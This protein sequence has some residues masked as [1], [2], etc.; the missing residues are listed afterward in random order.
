MIDTVID[1]VEEES[2][3]LSLH[4]TLCSLRYNQLIHKFTE[5]DVRLRQIEENI[6]FIKETLQKM[7]NA[8]DKTYLKWGGF[9]IVTL[10]GVVIS[11]ALKLS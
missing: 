10:V 9:V 5:V 7:D 1:P 11:L 8:K 4:V 6:V 3:D 2:N